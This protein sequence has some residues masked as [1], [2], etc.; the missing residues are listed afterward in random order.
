M[1]RHYGVMMTECVVVTSGT[2]K[3]SRIGEIILL[4]FTDFD[5]NFLFCGDH[6]VNNHFLDSRD[7][8]VVI[9]GLNSNIRLPIVQK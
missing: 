3:G 1:C 4:V 2:K 5:Q 9:S 8:N 6:F 7:L